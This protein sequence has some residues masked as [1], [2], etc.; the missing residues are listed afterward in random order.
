MIEISALC[1]LRTN[2]KFKF[3]M[4]HHNHVNCCV[5]SLIFKGKVDIYLIYSN[6]YIYK[7][8]TAH[9]KRLTFEGFFTTHIHQSL[10]TKVSHF[11]DARQIFIFIDVRCKRR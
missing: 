6:I 9:V 10:V 1:S 2:T 7:L 3:I 8:C 11:F 5:K 4:I